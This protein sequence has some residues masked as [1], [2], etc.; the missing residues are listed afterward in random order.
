MFRL[1]KKSQSKLIGLHPHLVA[2]VERAIELTTQD[3]TVF[4]GV[5]SIN[6][7]KENVAK[8]V[9]TTLHGSRHLIGQDGYAHAVDLVPYIHGKLAW[10]W[11]GCYKIA[12]AVRQASI[13][14][15]I[16]IRWGGVWNQNLAD[17]TGTTKQAQQKYVDAR[18][19][20]GQRAFA[21]GPHFELPLSPEY[22]QF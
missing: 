11:E 8:G 16:P 13:Q 10:D 22:P 6:Q 9:S 2:V 3:F 18:M 7:Q 5:R 15:N 4:E 17:I 20:N 1:S 14:L 21:D 12:E 19:K